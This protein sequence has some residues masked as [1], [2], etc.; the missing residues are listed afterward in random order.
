MCMYVYL[1]KYMHTHFLYTC[2]YISIVFL[3]CEV[4]A[5]VKTREYNVI[6]LLLLCKTLEH[7]CAFSMLNT[8]TGKIKEEKKLYY[9]YHPKNYDRN[10]SL[11]TYIFVKVF[12]FKEFLKRERLRRDFVVYGLFQVELFIA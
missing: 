1:C 11:L 9:S 12:Y 3:F 6:L 2:V 4:G 5:Y 8:S 7:A 10:I